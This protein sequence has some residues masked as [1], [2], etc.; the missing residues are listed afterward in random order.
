MNVLESA[1]KPALK[2][3]SATAVMG[4]GVH[5]FHSNWL[6]TGPDTDVLTMLI[7]LTLLLVTGVAVYLV[8]ARI[9]NCRELTSVLE[10]L[11]LQ[12]FHSGHIDQISDAGE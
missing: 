2:I 9:L 10:L 1:L 12:K 5:Y 3:I 7:N 6:H 8:V 4:F 11:R